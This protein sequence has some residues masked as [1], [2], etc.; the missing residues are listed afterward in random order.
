[1]RKF[2]IGDRVRVIKEPVFV[3]MYPNDVWKMY[4][5]DFEESDFGNGLVLKNNFG[6][7][8]LT[9]LIG[10]KG[11]IYHFQGNMFEM[12]LP[13]ESRKCGWWNI[14]FDNDVTVPRGLE[15]F[16]ENEIELI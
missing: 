15:G 5:Q 9:H 13:E 2:K 16:D 6:R 8:N 1:M 4:P 3:T 7:A 11:T 10:E 12:H 14:K